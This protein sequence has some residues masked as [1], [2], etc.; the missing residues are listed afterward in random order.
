[1]NKHIKKPMSFTRLVINHAILYP[2]MH[3]VFA[4]CTLGLSLLITLPF[5]LIDL[6]LYLVKRSRY[7]DALLVQHQAD[8]LDALR[9]NNLGLTDYTK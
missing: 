2:I 4:A 1:M 5:Q 8:V 6:C 7:K 9:N 3:V